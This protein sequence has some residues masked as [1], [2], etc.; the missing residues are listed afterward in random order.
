MAAGVSPSRDEGPP[1]TTCLEAECGCKQG[2]PGE[3]HARTRACHPGTVDL[4]EVQARWDRARELRAQTNG[5]GKPRYTLEQI[6]QQFDPPISRQRIHQML[7]G[8]R[9][10]D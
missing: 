2:T 10:G 4:E 7:T 1:H 3:P 9:P 8:P 5:E 6:G